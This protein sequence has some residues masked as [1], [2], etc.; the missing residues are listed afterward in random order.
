[1]ELPER[2]FVVEK[3]GASNFVMAGTQPSETAELGNSDFAR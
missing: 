1:M 3:S 2:R